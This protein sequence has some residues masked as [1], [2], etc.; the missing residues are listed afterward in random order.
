MKNSTKVLTA[1][2]AGMAAGGA[3]G[4]LFAPG[5]G[6]DSRKKFDEKVKEFSKVLNGEC[7]REQLKMVKAKLEQHRERLE[8]HIEKINSRLEPQEIPIK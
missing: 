8:K 7:S 1:L 6:S 5:R 4:V 2:A 3:M